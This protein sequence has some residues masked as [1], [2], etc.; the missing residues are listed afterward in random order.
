MNNRFF[1]IALRVLLV[2]SLLINVIVLGYVLQVRSLTHELGLDGVRVPR[3][4][5]QEFIQLAKQDDSI[6]E[7]TRALGEAR[8]H[9]NEAILTDPYDAALVAE[10]GRVAAA[11]NSELRALTDPVLLQAATNVAKRDGRAP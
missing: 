7:K 5:R 1:R 8:R 9:L 3:E 4:I 10:L 6:L 2:V 11:A